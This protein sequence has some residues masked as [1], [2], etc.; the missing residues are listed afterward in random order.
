MQWKT[1]LKSCSE[2][3]GGLAAISQYRER[4]SP[5]ATSLLEGRSQAH[6]GEVKAVFG[7]VNEKSLA[8]RLNR[9]VLIRKEMVKKEVKDN[10]KEWIVDQNQVNE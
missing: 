6:S 2:S 3:G 1:L 10:M 8:L 5:G 9:A 4:Q 7:V